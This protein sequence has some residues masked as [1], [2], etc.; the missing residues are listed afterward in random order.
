MCSLYF[1]SRAPLFSETNIIIRMA[2]NQAVGAEDK[3]PPWG[4]APQFWLR[5]PGLCWVPAASLVGALLC[6][7]CG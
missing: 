4:L 1:G 5:K 3:L 7:P 6:P 2:Q